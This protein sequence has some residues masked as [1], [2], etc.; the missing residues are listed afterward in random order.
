MTETIRY[1]TKPLGKRRAIPLNL[2]LDAA[3]HPEWPRGLPMPC[4]SPACPCLHFAVG[5]A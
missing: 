3:P 4:T 1:R 5:V 2:D